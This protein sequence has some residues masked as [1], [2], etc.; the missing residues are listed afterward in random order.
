MATQVKYIWPIQQAVTDF[1]SQRQRLKQV[2]QRLGW[3]LIGCDL[4]ECYGED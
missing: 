3:R 1:G 4:I 2:R